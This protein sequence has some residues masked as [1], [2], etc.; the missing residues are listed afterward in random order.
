M[1]GI[2]EMALVSVASRG[3]GTSN[4]E[5]FHAFLADGPGINDVQ[6][7]AWGYL[8]FA[9]RLGLPHLLARLLA[10]PGVDVNLV[11]YGGWT[12]LS[13]A[14]FNDHVDCVR[15][16]IADP[17]TDWNIVA[18]N[19]PR[20]LLHQARNQNSLD[21]LIAFHPLPL[22]L[23]YQQLSNPSVRTDPRLAHFLKCPIAVRHQNRL[24]LKVIDSCAGELFAVIVLAC[25]DYIRLCPATAEAGNAPL[26]RRFLAMSR[27]M[28]LELQMT[29]AWRSVGSVREII[30]RAVS[31][32]A[33]DSL[34]FR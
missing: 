2:R 21:W 12:P 15:L 24:K 18:P 19:Y 26:L 4:V 7:N 6:H 30:T 10:V 11:A 3:A 9:C 13:F 25:D 20:T 32:P 22:V 17:R 31:D 1:R 16:L 8:H 29:L 5:S 14:A 28:P 34:L 27:R 23:D 33:F